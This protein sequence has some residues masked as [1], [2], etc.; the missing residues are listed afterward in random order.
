MKF[1]EDNV[2]R[3]VLKNSFAK[4]VI[5]QRTKLPEKV[6]SASCINSLKTKIDK[7][8]RHK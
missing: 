5:E 1:Y 8:L 7:Y 4:R 3:D 2:N 6:I